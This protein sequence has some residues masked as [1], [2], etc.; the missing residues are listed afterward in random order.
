MS[1]ADRRSALTQYF[2]RWNGDRLIGIC[3][4][5]ID[6]ERK[7]LLEQA[8]SGTEWVPTEI[9]MRALTKG[10]TDLD[11]ITEEQAREIVPAAFR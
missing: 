2:A 1:Q 4:L 8:W 3:R 7:T 9:V 11:E 10:D 6:D 5:A